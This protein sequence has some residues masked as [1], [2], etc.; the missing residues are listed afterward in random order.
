MWHFEKS[1]QYNQVT[2]EQGHFDKYVN[3]FLKLKAE[4]SGYPPGV[5]TE[6]A[7]RAFIAE[8]YQRE[9]IRLDYANIKHNPGLRSLA[10]LMLNSFWGKLNTEFISIPDARGCVYV[11][12]CMQVFNIRDILKNFVTY[13]S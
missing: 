8:F 13:L 12:I 10:K 11:C 4:A 6:E 9:G 5:V 1:R 3:S 7:K 2:G